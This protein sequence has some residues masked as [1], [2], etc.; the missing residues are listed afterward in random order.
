MRPV[1]FPKRQAWTSPEVAANYERARFRGPLQRRKHRR[2]VALVRALL[3]RAGL[4]GG[5]GQARPRVLDLPCGTG[6]LLG[7]LEDAGYRAIGADV[8]P[9]MLARARG[10]SRRLFV[11]DAERLALAGTSVQA[12]VSLR[13]L[14]HVEDLD[15][16]RRILAELARVAERCVVGQVRYDATLK[17]GLRRLRHR[18]GLFARLRPALTRS[19]VVRELEAAGLE[20][21]ALER[22]SSCFSDKAL[23]LAVPRAPN[24]PVAG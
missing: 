8:S 1:S 21:V 20:L 4:G 19:D 14:F 24:E 18:L 17:H 7:A 15:V 12:V 13:F 9:A 23:F 3:A 5:L 16:R 6:R 22:V 11:G 10:R 2:D